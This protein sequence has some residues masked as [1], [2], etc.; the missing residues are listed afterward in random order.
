MIQ[1][2]STD[3][4]IAVLK[5]NVVI[6]DVLIA[7]LDKVTKKSVSGSFWMLAWTL[8]DPVDS[9]VVVVLLRK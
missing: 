6:K 9:E 8:S 1:A 3:F 7:T 4:A 2:I 5:E